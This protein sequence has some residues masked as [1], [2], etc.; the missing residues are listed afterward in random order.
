M[1]ASLVVTLL[2]SAPLLSVLT[3]PAWAADPMAFV[4]AGD[5]AAAEAAVA[6]A[7]DPVARQ[8]VTFYRLLTPGAATPG[9]I[10]A[11]RAANPDWPDQFELA[12]RFQQALAA[13]ADPA[14]AARF[15]VPGRITL[16]AALAQC[17]RLLTGSAAV[18]AARAAWAHGLDDP[19]F[20]RRWATHFTAADA[21]AR[22]RVTLRTDPSA[23]R[24][25][26]PRLAAAARAP[27]MAALALRTGAAD[28]QTRIRALPGADQDRPGLA[29]AEA[30]ALTSDHPNRALAFWRAH[31]F[32]AERAAAPARRA[33]FWA[34]RQAL[35]R[36]LLAAGNAAEA[37]TMADDRMQTAPAPVASSGF[38][39]GFIALTALHRPALAAAD[40]DRLAV[41]HAAITSARRQYWLARA[42]AA[43][44]AAP[45]GAYRAAGAYPTTFYG[46]LAARALGQS[47]IA[48]VAA[49]AD[50]AF[51]RAQA[52]RFTGHEL[53]RAAL[54]LAAWHQPGRARAFLFRMAQ[55]A[56]DLAEQT[57]AARLALALGIPE[58]AV[59]IARRIGLEGGMLPETG[60]PMAADPPQAP[61]GAPPQGVGPGGVGQE[62]VGQGV[63]LGAAQPAV[64]LAL[65]RQESSFDPGAISPSGARGLMQLM[66]ATAAQVARAL[67]VRITTVAL[68]TDRERNI[69]L[70]SAYFSQLLARYDGSLPL[71]V[72]AYN[73][74]PR[75]VDQWLAANG[76]PRGHPNRMIDWIERIPFGETRNYVQRVLENM[77]VYLAHTGTAAP[78]LLAQWMPGPK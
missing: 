78:A 28:A 32:A 38:L 56:P 11:F 8:L 42:A 6:R 55:V 67:G 66:P 29:L 24:A 59:F 63:A 60:W 13:D 58:T 46:Q 53:V 14:D 7:P 37:Y 43:A 69:R 72:A 5:W 18:A 45:A 3:R 40:F 26:I 16:P 33:A 64:I 74:G 30:R 25:L 76:D 19:A 15:C 1:P 50:P 57:L 31:G 9:Q 47:P 75:R 20:A 52:I 73:A 71:A 44:G 27:A 23:A 54:L 36:A 21:A 65:I 10:A 62:G 49:I 22:F 41:S 61:T 77:V 48:R 39:S 70:G 51:T 68:T 2:L 17:A 4:A 12:R 34:A 35:A